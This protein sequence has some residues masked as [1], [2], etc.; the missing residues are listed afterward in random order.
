MDPRED[1]KMAAKEV[2]KAAEIGDASVFKSFSDD[3]NV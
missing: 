1:T 2:F 3:N